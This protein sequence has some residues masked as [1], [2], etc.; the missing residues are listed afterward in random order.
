[1]AHSNLARP[2]ARAAFELAR[3]SDTLAEWSERLGLLAAVAADK[4]VAVL[5]GDPR[6]TRGQRAEIVLGICGDHLDQAAAN[7]VRLLA[8][9]GRLTLLEAIAEQYELLRA[10]A[11]NRVDARVSSA[12]E[13]DDTQRDRLAAA[14]KKRLSR[15]VRLECEVDERLIG[16][17]VVRA[18][19]LVI[20]ASVRGRL[21][22]LASRLA[23]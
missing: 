15:D 7:L 23:H 12:R 5:L 10:D 13:L 3:E 6:Y 18:G 17:V 9:N 19:D 8:E 20:D 22:R 16:G 1:M 4:R 2:Y 11:E 14:L 21:E